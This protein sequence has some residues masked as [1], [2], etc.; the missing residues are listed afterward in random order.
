ML[1]NIKTATLLMNTATGLVLVTHYTV[2]ISTITHG[3]YIEII[4][5]YHGS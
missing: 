4:Q 5:L 2:N 1:V 3:M